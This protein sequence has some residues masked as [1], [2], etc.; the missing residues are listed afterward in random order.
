MFRRIEADPATHAA[1]GRV[2]ADE[3]ELEFHPRSQEVSVLDAYNRTAAQLL[4]D[5]PREA[6]S[7]LTH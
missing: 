3:Q 4:G 7:G 5:I 6:D 2:V 1:G